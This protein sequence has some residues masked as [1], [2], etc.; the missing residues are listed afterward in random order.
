MP[1]SIRPRLIVSIVEIIFAWSDGLRNA[2][3]MT[4]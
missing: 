3:Q 2:V 4:M 1:R